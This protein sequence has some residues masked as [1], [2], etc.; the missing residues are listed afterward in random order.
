MEIEFQCL[1]P[2]LLAS[3]QNFNSAANER[4]LRKF[5]SQPESVSR[6]KTK[7]TAG[8]VPDKV[9]FQF[10][11]PQIRTGFLLM[12]FL[13]LSS[14]HYSND[15]GKWSVVPFHFPFQ[16][17]CSGLAMLL[18]G[19]SRSFSMFLDVDCLSSIL[20]KWKNFFPFSRLNYYSCLFYY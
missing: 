4:N 18:S 7:K 9:Y 5:N 19:P 15:N 8:S 14:V 10:F 2:F 1:V 17:C 6:N 20:G 11:P 3:F 12:I 13:F 16:P